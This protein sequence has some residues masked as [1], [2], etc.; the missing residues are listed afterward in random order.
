ME[1]FST[2]T[3]Q[4]HGDNLE[5]HDFCLVYSSRLQHVLM[6]KGIVLSAIFCFS[7]PLH[8]S[9]IFRSVVHGFFSLKILPVTKLT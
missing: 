5:G 8:A 4:A 7:H 1:K 6:I 3:A 2:F 9:S